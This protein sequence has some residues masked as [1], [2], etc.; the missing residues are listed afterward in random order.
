MTRTE[1]LKQLFDFFRIKDENNSLFSIYDNTLCNKIKYNVDWQ[2]L[3]DDITAN[4]D[5]RTMPMP[6][7]I[8][9]TSRKF[10]IVKFS[11]M[12]V[13][14]SFKSGYSD[15]FEISDEAKTDVNGFIDRHK[16][17]IAKVVIAPKE[18]QTV[19]GDV[20][21]YPF[22]KEKTIRKKVKE[23]AQRQ[24]VTDEKVIFKKTEEL[25]NEKL[26]EKRAELQNQ[27]KTIYVG[28]GVN[29]ETEIF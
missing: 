17:K 3:F 11:N 21:C 14:V 8:I 16:D 22:I 28:A 13:I 12:H 1:F 26:A 27:V 2:A 4:V 29:E 7:V 25:I 19:A 5:K 15:S 23:S 20:G 6:K 9:N 24:G 10:K 18:F